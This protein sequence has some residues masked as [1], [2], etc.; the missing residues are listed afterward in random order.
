M[1]NADEG[2]GLSLL[3]YFGVMVAVLAILAVPVYWLNAPTVYANPQLA[4]SNALPGGPAYE[5]R[6]RREFP[7]AVL[8]SQPIVDAAVLAQINAKAAKPVRVAPR[9]ARHYAQARD[10]DTAERPA[11]RSFFSLF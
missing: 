11:P 4:A 1:R 8:N 9:P 3:V 5:S 7:L 2:L 6:E 10:T